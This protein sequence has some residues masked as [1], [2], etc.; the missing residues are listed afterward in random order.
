M[1]KPR[2]AALAGDQEA[3]AKALVE[4]A[5]SLEELQS[6]NV[7]QQQALAGALGM[8]AD[9]LADSLVTQEA[10]S[11]QAQADLDRKAEEVKAN[12]QLQSLQE[13]QTRAMEKFSETVQMLGPLLLV[14]A[15]AAAAIAIAMSF[16]GATP[17]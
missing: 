10:L 12:E 9:Q 13:R 6:M 2:A 11:T 8:S 5:G 4:E 17:P 14:A 16:G 3:L 7:L 15:A 1:K